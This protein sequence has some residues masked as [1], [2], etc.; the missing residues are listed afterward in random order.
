MY[1]EIG[2]IILQGAVTEH[3]H[4]H[5]HTH[6]RTHARGRHPPPEWSGAGERQGVDGPGERD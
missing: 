4:T 5:T 3:T 2:I 1:L 6:T